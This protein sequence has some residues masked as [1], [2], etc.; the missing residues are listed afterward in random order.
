M[1]FVQT[2]TDA[3]P[4]TIEL[5]LSRVATKEDEVIEE[6]PERVMIRACTKPLFYGFFDALDDVGHVRISDAGA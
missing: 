5:E 6:T 2:R 4:S 3:K 1:R